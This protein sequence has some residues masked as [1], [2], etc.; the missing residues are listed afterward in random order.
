MGYLHMHA[1]E[2]FLKLKNNN[3]SFRVTVHVIFWLIYWLI[4]YYFNTISLNIFA[5][6][7]L[8][9]LEPLC[10]IVNLLIF[11]YPL[12]YVVWPR[13]FRKGKYATGVL[14]L[15]MQVLAYTILYEL[16][17]RMLI[18]NCSSCA[19]IL[20]Q[21]P[22]SMNQGLRQTLFEGIMSSFLSL[23]IVYVL[24]AR[25][26]PVIAFKLSLD[27]TKERNAAI[28]L[29]KENIL[30]EFN[31]L[32]SQVNPHFLFNTLNN[33]HSLVV[34][35]RKQ[36]ASATIAKLSDFLRHSLY[37]SGSETI[38]LSKE[39]KLLQD[40]IELEKLRLNKTEATLSA[41]TNNTDVQ[42]PPLL[43]MPLVENAFKYSADSLPVHSFIHINIEQNNN[44]LHFHIRNNYD[45]QKRNNP[46]GIG[47]KNLK[48]RLMNYYPGKHSI[49]T[50]DIENTYDVK[51]S[52][53]L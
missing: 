30:L 6:T 51:I 43:F 10:S 49:E 1:L 29:E 14:L 17:E 50:T 9:W 22:A 38:P 34:Q 20:A 16:Q 46:G 33:I 2:R 25:L 40:Y 4:S 24:I 19:D 12:M 28:E 32:K 15:F 31:F 42:L 48:K 27:F 18:T 41:N 37:E 13:F 23:G 35:E 52:I 21:M 47:L 11:Y 26:S 44:N 45:P 36:D 39:I 7:P 3:R 5:S 8:A 53:E